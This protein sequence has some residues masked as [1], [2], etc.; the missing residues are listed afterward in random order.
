MDQQI[1]ADILQDQFKSVFSSP[2]KDSGTLPLTTKTPKNFALPDLFITNEDVINA[3][4]EVK[5]DSS[6]PNSDIPAI[7][8]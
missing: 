8:F 5:M 1:I 4:N 3:I 7:V 6:C 2:K